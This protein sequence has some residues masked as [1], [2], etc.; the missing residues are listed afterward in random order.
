[1]PTPTPPRYNFQPGYGTPTPTPWTPNVN[2]YW[3]PP[4]GAQQ[5]YPTSFAGARVYGESQAAP[6]Y[7]SGGGMPYG[8]TGFSGSFG[9]APQAAIDP[10]DL[11][12]DPE[13]IR[14]YPQLAGMTGRQYQDFL[15][16]TQQI[17]LPT[18]WGDASGG[19]GGQASA[20]QLAWDR[21]KWGA[22][23]PEQQRQFN[24]QFNQNVGQSA[25]DERFRNAQLAAQNAQAA[26]QMQL[27]RDQLNQAQ[28]QWLKE[29]QARNGQQQIANQQWTSQFDETRRMAD[30]GQAN[31]NA[32]MQ[33]A[34][35]QFNVGQGNTERA[36]GQNQDQAMLAQAN[37]DRQ[38]RQAEIASQWQRMMDAAAAKTQKEQFQ[39]QLD[40]Q[41]QQAMVTS[42]GRKF[43]PNAMMQ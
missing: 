34:M 30:F 18:G 22:E 33:E 35:R 39:K 8:T 17:G 5:Q 2:Y 40:A 36:F 42:F 9:A 20:N 19:A 14:R 10:L 37:T 27:N 29:Y 12:L 16:Y 32:Q 38:A 25:N 7:Y 3:S 43:A 41:N 11:P 28:E 31:T 21:Q 6:N 23:F 26:Q 1:M 4:S 13:I 24:A 15:T